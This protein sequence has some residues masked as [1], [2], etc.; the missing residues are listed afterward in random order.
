MTTIFV[1]NVT[2]FDKTNMYKNKNSITSKRNAGNHTMFPVKN[3]F[4]FE[5]KIFH[6]FSQFLKYHDF[7]V[8]VTMN[9]VWNIR[10]HPDFFPFWLL[11]VSVVE[12]ESE[13]WRLAMF[14]QRQT[15]IPD[16]KPHPTIAQLHQLYEYEGDLEQKTRT[17]WWLNGSRKG[18]NLSPNV[19]NMTSF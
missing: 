19:E 16:N 14:S 6:T 12:W 9:S 8:L 18:V 2:L 11:F 15:V 4:Q 3:L 1:I 7:K 13:N 17:E 10:N 5:R